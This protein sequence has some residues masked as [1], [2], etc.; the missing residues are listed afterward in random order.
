MN[1]GEQIADISTFGTMF[2]ILDTVI[3]CLLLKFYSPRKPSVGASSSGSAISAF[4]PQTIVVSPSRTSA[5]PSAV[6]M[7]PILHFRYQRLVSR[8]RT[9]PG[10]A[11]VDIE[12]PE[13]IG[14]ACIGPYTFC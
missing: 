5:D 4:T 1:F 12:V 7:D 13:R 8:T 10:L 14:F 2:R 9:L 3:Q 6:V 11:Y